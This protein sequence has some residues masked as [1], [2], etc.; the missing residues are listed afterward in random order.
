[1]YANVAL[2]CY[3]VQF[4]TISFFVYVLKIC[5]ILL[6]WDSRSDTGHKCAESLVTILVM[7]QRVKIFAD[8]VA[9]NV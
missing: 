8:V 5:L 2:R 6:Q 7:Q 9:T 4:S 1:M 3:V